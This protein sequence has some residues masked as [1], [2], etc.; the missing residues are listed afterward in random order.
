MVEDEYIHNLRMV[1]QMFNDKKITINSDKCIFGAEKVEFV[2]HVLDAERATFSKTMFNSL[3]EF[4]KP[5]NMKELRS[6][7]RMDNY[8]RDHIQNHSTIIQPLQLMIMEGAK[9]RMV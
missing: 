1:F 7:V 6:L 9:M 8:F 3:V 5:S 4:I 2:G